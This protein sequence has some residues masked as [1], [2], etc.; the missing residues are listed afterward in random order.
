MT[1][2]SQ[3]TADYK[4]KLSEW[5]SQFT[6]DDQ[7][8]QA[9][10]PVDISQDS[11]TRRAHKQTCPILIYISPGVPRLNKLTPSQVFKSEGEEF[12]LSLSFVSRIQPTTGPLLYGSDPP[13]SLPLHYPALVQVPSPGIW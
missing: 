3:T 8:P 13:V 11:Q 10:V 4:H 6:S 5:L 1:E 7:C 2:R 12:D 9:Q